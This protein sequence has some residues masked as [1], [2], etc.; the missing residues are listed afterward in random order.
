MF[1]GDV[2]RDQQRYSVFF[3]FSKTFSRTPLTGMG[4]M[5]SSSMVINKV[6]FQSVSIY[7]GWHLRWASTPLILKLKRGPRRVYPKP[8]QDF[9]VFGR[10]IWLATEEGIMKPITETLEFE[11]LN[12]PRAIEGVHI[13][14]FALQGD[15]TL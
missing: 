1:G 10:S 11:A 5:H 13:E 12:L 7:L 8:V 15:N 6:G 3:L 4:N 9:Q 2:G 14:N